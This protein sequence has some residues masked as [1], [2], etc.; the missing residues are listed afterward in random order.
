MQWQS[1]MVFFDKNALSVYINFSQNIK[2]G[3]HGFDGDI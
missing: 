3:R 2:R 1:K